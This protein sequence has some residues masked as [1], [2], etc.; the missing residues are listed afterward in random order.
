MFPASVT[1][2]R[3]Y[4][5]LHPVLKWPKKVVNVSRYR[6]CDW[7]V[8]NG[9]CVILTRFNKKKKKRLIGTKAFSPKRLLFR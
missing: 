3:H 1:Y 4:L 6:T 7:P 9:Y 2:D 5:V 8:K